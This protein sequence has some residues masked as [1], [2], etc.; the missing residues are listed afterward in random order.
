MSKG[1]HHLT[2][3]KKIIYL[4]WLDRTVLELW[5]GYLDVW[6]DSSLSFE[7]KENRSSE[8]KSL[9]DHF[10]KICEQI[11]MEVSYAEIDEFR[12]GNSKVCKN[13][14]Y[15]WSGLWL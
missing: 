4:I 8:K 6:T 11:M 9:I 7:E 5:S 14:G 3:E 2:K 13:L 15:D 10:E 1:F 12:V